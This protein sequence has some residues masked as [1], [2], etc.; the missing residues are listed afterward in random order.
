M[1]NDMLPEA[2]WTPTEEPARPRPSPDA[3]YRRLTVGGWTA[4]EAGN[5]TAHLEGLGPVRH[6]WTIREIDHLLFLREMVETGRL[7]S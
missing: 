5:L 3:L 2:R 6:G 7:T 4:R 1:V